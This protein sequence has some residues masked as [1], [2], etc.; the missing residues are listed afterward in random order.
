MFGYICHFRGR[1]PKRGRRRMENV[2]VEIG[3]ID[4]ARSGGR[5][6]GG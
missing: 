3:Q 2:R 4:R 5:G 1:I 6:R